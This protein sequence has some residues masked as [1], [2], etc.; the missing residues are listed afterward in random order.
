M[1][2]LTSL[3]GSRPLH[4]GGEDRGEATGR[5]HSQAIRPCASLPGSA[6]AAGRCRRD[7]S[8]V[9]RLRSGRVSSQKFG[10]RLTGGPRVTQMAVRGSQDGMDIGKF[11]VGLG[12]HCRELDRLLV[13]LREQR[14][15]ALAQVP[16]DQQRVARAEPGPHDAAIRET[17]A[18]FSLRKRPEIR[19]LSLPHGMRLDHG[20]AQTSPVIDP[21]SKKRTASGKVAESDFR[22]RFKSS[23]RAGPG[24]SIARSD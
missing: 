5:G 18:R 9:R 24:R 23:S 10:E 17:G 4:I 14:R 8:I 12:G 11:R 16:D 1:S 15:P 7:G 20:M 3:A 2:L 6:P 19:Q 13:A 22:R 21:S